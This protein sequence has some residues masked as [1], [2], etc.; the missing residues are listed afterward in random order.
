SYLP[1]ATR[2]K[3]LKGIYYELPVKSAQV[4]SAVLI[5]GLF[6]EG[7]TTVVEKTQTRNHTEN[8]LHAFGADIK[9]NNDEITVTN[10]QP[11]QATDVEVPGDISSAAFFLVAGAIVPGSKLSLKNVGLNETR[12]GILDVLYA[13]DAN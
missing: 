10:K 8:M 9:T 7:E 1:I 12:T 4:K 2:G 5:A 11:L 3:P 6:A 13:M